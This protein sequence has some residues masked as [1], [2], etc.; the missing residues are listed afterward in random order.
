MN[1]R[2]ALFENLRPFTPGQQYQVIY[3]L[4][5]RVGAEAN[6]S[7][8]DKMAASN[9]KL[10]LL[11]RYYQFANAASRNGEVSVVVTEVRH[12]L[13]DFPAAQKTYEE[14]LQ[15][16]TS[17]LFTRNALDDLRLSLESLLRQLLAN[18]KPLE[19]QVPEIGRY[20]K[21]RGGSPELA[22]MFEK[23]IDYYSKYQ[24]TYV[25]HD[26]SVPSSEAEFIIEV[27]AC[28][29]KHLLRIREAR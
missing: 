27:T 8:E 29:M 12:W 26:D 15:K 3:E 10:T 1:K 16:H 18:A 21:Q 25:K 2:T 19:K 28:F 23:L 11:A 9:L 20:V 6:A 13:A 14:A 17:G 7:F 4:S 24:N 22:N 5:D